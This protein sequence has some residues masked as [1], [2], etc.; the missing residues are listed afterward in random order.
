M[1]KKDLIDRVAETTGVKKGDARKTVDAALGLIR[2]ALEAG[3]DVTLP[4][5]GR[6][7]V[8]TRGEGAEAVAHYK[9]IL[10]R[11]RDAAAEPE[12]A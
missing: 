4:P 7:K 8:R 6:I 1:K 12:D 2:D 10:G 5:L 3:T 11:D 9:L